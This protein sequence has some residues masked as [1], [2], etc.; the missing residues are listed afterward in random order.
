M[1]GGF[2]IL[3]AIDEIIELNE[4]YGVNEFAKELVLF[5]SDG[6]DTAFAFDIRNNVTQ[7]VSVPFI[8]MS[9]EK[10]TLRF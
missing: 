1:W 9:I 4:A 8:G 5:G 7:I 10:I 2:L 3:W 6:G